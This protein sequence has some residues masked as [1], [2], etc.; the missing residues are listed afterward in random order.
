MTRL[1]PLPPVLGFRYDESMH[2]IKKLVFAPIF[3]VSMFGLCAL[4]PG[5]LTSSNGLFSLSWEVFVQL[6]LFS[7]ILIFTSFAF[8]VFTGLSQDFKFVG[9]VILMSSAIPFLCLPTQQSIIISIGFA[10]A[11]FII[12][13]LLINNL[14]KYI[15]FQA[16][17]LFGGPIRNTTKLLLVVI[18][19][20]YYVML[21]AQ[22]S[23]N[24][25]QIPDSLIDASLKFATP[26]L[27]TSQNVQGVSIAQNAQEMQLPSLSKEQ[28][29]LLRKNPQLLEQYGLDPSVLDMLDQPQQTSPKS[30]KSD[31]SLTT[32]STLNPQ[33]FLRNTLKSQ[34]QKMIDP[35]MR[36]IAPFMALMLY[37]TLQGIV[38][39]LSIFLSL[40]LW[41]TF[42]ILEKSGFITFTEEMCPVRKMVV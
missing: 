32:P 4:L 35:Y 34:L 22:I 19:I 15:T 6:I 33:T 18:A 23:Q 31:T 11:F 30:G 38:S 1:G 36:Y 16:S 29:D 9:P 20:A 2:Y 24:G 37:L 8:V 12:A 3:L 40:L 10:I 21:Q 25:F 13:L 39:L 42:Y 27:P 14:K 26:Q 41:I 17:A 5:I 28:I 7:G